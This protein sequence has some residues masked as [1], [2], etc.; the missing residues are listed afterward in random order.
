MPGG[1]LSAWALFGWTEDAQLDLS[2]LH[3]I[4]TGRNRFGRFYERDA[5]RSAICV[6]GSVRAMLL[7]LVWQPV[8][9]RKR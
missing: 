1:A 5:V 3:R 2:I 4:F 7:G 8:S 9:E 6:S